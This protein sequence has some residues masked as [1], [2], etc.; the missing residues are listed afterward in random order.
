MEQYHGLVLVFVM[1]LVAAVQ[2]DGQV[3]RRLLDEKGFTIKYWNERPDCALRQNQYLAYEGCPCQIKG[4]PCAAGLR[5][6]TTDINIRQG[7]YGHSH[8]RKDSNPATYVP[9]PRKIYTGPANWLDLPIPPGEEWRM[10]AITLYSVL[11][12]IFFL[13]RWYVACQFLVEMAHL[14]SLFIL[15]LITWKPL[16]RHWNHNKTNSSVKRKIFRW[17]HDWEETFQEQRLRFRA[18]VRY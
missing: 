12:D 10:A 11:Y 14:C 15:S 1:F 2:A 6:T 16:H 9:Q 17:D 4:R 3:T 18:E 13:L 7:V 8:C 5:C